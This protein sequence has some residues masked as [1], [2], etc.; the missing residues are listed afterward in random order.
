MRSG[1][2]AMQKARR[3]VRPG[4]CQIA[5]FA[6]SRVSSQTEFLDCLHL[7]KNHLTLVTRLT[8]TRSFSKIAS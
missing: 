3:G 8:D 7:Q 2:R 6:T 1:E 5:H 4:F